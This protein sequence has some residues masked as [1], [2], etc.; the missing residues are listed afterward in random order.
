VKF[1]KLMDLSGVD[2]TLPPDSVRTARVLARAAQSAAANR[3]VY[4]GCTGWGNPAWQGTYYPAK[5]KPEDYLYHYSRLFNTIELNTTHYRIPD[6]ATIARWQEQ[7]ATHFSFCPKV[8]QQISH[9]S[10]LA[11]EEPTLR[12]AETVAGLGDKLGPCFIQLPDSHG[13]QGVHL[14]HQFLRLWPSTIDLHWELRHP[15][16]F[17]ADTGAA[18]E[19]FDALEAA[20]HGAVITDVA[21]R[22][23]VLHM[24]LTAPVLLLR[25]VGN[26]LHPTDYSR[27]AA[28]FERIA[29]WW[30]R[31]L[32][33]AYVF[34]HQPAIE[35]VPP[36]AAY[37]ARGLN[38][39]LGIHLH[40]PAPIP[41]PSGPQG[42]LF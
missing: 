16:W 9:R 8:P 18:S 36:F 11:A 13:P 19:G 10:R 22:R 3:Q 42:S 41:P 35:L 37:W 17:P 29:D 39:A 2:F 15:D 7:A 20:G 33:A 23:D 12:F 31:G 21:G 25:F 5:S 40:E 30:Q 32:R 24:E 28:W 6:A 27:S 4:I 26:G 38:Q 34:I 14:I 1:G